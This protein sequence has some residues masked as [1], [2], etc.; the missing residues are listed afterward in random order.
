M[1]DVWMLGITI[2]LFGATLGFI[3]LCQRLMESK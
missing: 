2:L 1:D 3:L